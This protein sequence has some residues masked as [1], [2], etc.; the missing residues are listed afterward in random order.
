MPKS[1]FRLFGPVLE[2]ICVAVAFGMLLLIG[3]RIL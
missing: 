1:Q 2:L 3:S